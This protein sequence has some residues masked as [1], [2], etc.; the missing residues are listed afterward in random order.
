MNPIDDNINIDQDG[1][2]ELQFNIE[3]EFLDDLLNHKKDKIDNT[4]INIVMN[5]GEK[6]YNDEL[7]NDNY[8]EEFLFPIGKK[9]NNLQLLFTS[10][11]ENNSNEL[12]IDINI[13]I[14]YDLINQNEM[15]PLY[16]YYVYCIKKEVIDNIEYEFIWKTS[17]IY[18]HKE[19]Y[20][21]LYWHVLDSK[22]EEIEVQDLTKLEHKII[23]KCM[24][25]SLNINIIDTLNLLFKFPYDIRR[26]T[27]ILIQN[28]EE[29]IE[30]YK[31]QKIVDTNNN[32]NDVIYVIPIDT[33]DSDDEDDDIET[34]DNEEELDNYDI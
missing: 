7:V 5:C 4:P 24:K 25:K 16:M 23:S 9:E 31:K 30:E 28:F 34:D 32:S 17:Y 3:D 19:G 29:N 13:D 22:G 10:K 11:E 1:N 15:I 8:D 21:S 33:S 14:Q 26:D 27:S 6:L 2:I 20:L 18:R 12:L